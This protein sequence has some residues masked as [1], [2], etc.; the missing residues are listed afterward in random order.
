MMNHPFLHNYQLLIQPPARGQDKQGAGY[1][2]AP[3]G[4]RKHKGIDLSCYADSIICALRPGTVTKI[5]YP[6]PADD[7]KKGHLRYV[8]I[9]DD[10]NNDL[11]YFYVKPVVFINTVVETGQ[12]IGSSQQLSS[13]YPEIT[14][15][16]HFEVKKNGKII[17][18]TNILTGGKHG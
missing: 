5:G 17:D 1:F 10:Q 13:I 18:P 11:R 3:R 15:H 9:T 12:P 16:I 8:Q 14:D 6:Y 4:N 7:P 2:G